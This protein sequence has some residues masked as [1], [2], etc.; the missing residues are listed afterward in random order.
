MIDA[1]LEDLLKHAK[2][3][4]LGNPVM[5]HLHRLFEDRWDLVVVA[6][7]QE[8]LPLAFNYVGTPMVLTHTPSGV[9]PPHFLLLPINETGSPF[10]NLH[11][12]HSVEGVTIVD[13]G[14][15]PA[16]HFGPVTPAALVGLVTRYAQKG[17]GNLYPIAEIEAAEGG[18]TS[19]LVDW[20]GRPLWLWINP[21]SDDGA[22]SHALAVVSPRLNVRGY[23]AVAVDAELRPIF[24]DEELRAQRE[25]RN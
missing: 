14:L 10:F 5:A 2:R 22:I 7:G 6:D 20:E 24:S 11:K 23:D 3:D 19:V 16:D 25:S 1:T 12:I 9:K 13:D 21:P 4:Q 18:T 8:N 17:P 15:A